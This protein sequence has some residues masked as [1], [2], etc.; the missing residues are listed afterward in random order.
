[1]VFLIH[2]ELQ[3]T[4]NHTSDYELVLKAKIELHLF[5]QYFTP[6]TPPLRQDQS[7]TT[8]TPD[9]PSTHTSN[10]EQFLSINVSN[11]AAQCQISWPA[12]VCKQQRDSRA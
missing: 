8:L 2:T 1:L 3:C 6:H 7:E 4:V 10:A 11:R 5:Q 12:T 9:L